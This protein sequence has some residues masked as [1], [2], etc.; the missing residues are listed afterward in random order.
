MK[1]LAQESRAERFNFVVAAVAV[2]DAKFLI[3]KR[4]ANENLLPGVWALP[5]GS[6]NFLEDVEDAVR[7]ELREETG[8]RG[9]VAA[10]IGHS[11]FR[12]TIPGTEVRLHNVQ[13]NFLMTVHGADVVLDP[14]NHTEY[15]WMSFKKQSLRTLDEFT[16][17]IVESAI[18]FQGDVG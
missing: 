6:V 5:G 9:E 1:L 3:L 18:S 17:K 11:S 12:S 14:R 13:L 15:R 10:L 4:S 8:L 7:R 2:H 16:Q